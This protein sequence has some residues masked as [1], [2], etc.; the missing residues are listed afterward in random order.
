MLTEEKGGDG[1]MDERNRTGKEG[2]GCLGN[3]GI[4]GEGKGK[5]WMM[6]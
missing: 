4:E 6:G 2:G 3:C 1:E 5:Q